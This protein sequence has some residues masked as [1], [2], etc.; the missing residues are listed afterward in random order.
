MASRQELL[1]VKL[2][3]STFRDRASLLNWFL[4]D[5]CPRQDIDTSFHANVRRAVTKRLQELDA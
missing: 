1:N 3:V 4:L 5:W 2:K